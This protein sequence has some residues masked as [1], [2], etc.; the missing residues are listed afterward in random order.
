[1]GICHDHGTST[2]AHNGYFLFCIS[3]RVEKVCFTTHSPCYAG[4]PADLVL[5]FPAAITMPMTSVWCFSPAMLAQYGPKIAG[6]PF[7][8]P[9]KMERTSMASTSEVQKPNLSR[10]KGRR[11]DAHCSYSHVDESIP[12]WIRYMR[13][14]FQKTLCNR[15]LTIVYQL[16]VLVVTRVPNSNFIKFPHC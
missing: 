9:K 12:M 7:S 11:L 1:M 2:F 10:P 4:S 16:D 8:R 5:W 14:F 13:R 3:A 15:P 6:Q